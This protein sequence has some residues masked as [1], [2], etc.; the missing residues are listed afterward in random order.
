[1]L[2]LGWARPFLFLEPPSTRATISRTGLR[3]SLFKPHYRRQYFPMGSGSYPN[4]SY[5]TYIKYLDLFVIAFLW[6]ITHWCLPLR[7]RGL[8]ST[9][10]ILVTLLVGCQ[11]E[12]FL[13]LWVP[14]PRLSKYGWGISCRGGAGGSPLVLSWNKWSK[15]LLIKRKPKCIVNLH[16]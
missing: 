3:P 6:W 7:L 4:K 5:K 12:Q 10:G 11:I 16:K 2:N 8:K 13:P 15:L 14:G 1:M 9:C